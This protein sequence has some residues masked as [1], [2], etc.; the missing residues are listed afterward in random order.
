MT[1]PPLGRRRFLAL[2]LG[3]VSMIVGR[4]NA[5]ETGTGP[6]LGK[7]QPFT[8]DW[9]TDHARGLARRPFEHTPPRTAE[10]IKSID[11]DAVQKIKFRNSCGLWN[12]QNFPI[13]F[14]HLN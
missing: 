7:P 10:L 3:F 4:V 8:F 1:N 2:G 14:F 6:I 5:T 11:F 9:L 13:R 12:G